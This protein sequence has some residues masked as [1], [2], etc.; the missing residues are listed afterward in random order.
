MFEY[1]APGVHRDAVMSLLAAQGSEVTVPT[2][3]VAQGVS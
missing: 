3:R 1:P 2:G